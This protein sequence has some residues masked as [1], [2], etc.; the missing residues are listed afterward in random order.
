ML[1][2]LLDGIYMPHGYCLLWEPWLVTLHAASDVLTFAAYSAIPVAIWIFVSKRND[3]EMKGLARLFAA[4]ILWCG[5]THLFGFITLWRPVYELQGIVKSITAVVSVTTAIMIFPL[6][7]KA[8]A[9]PSPRQ[10]QSA[11]LKLEGEIAAHRRTL[12]ELEHARAELEKRVRER[13]RELQEATER[14]RLLFEHAPVAMIMVGQDG[15]VQQVNEAAVALFG[16]RRE[17]L[18]G[19]SVETLLPEESRASHSGLRRAYGEHPEPRRMGEGRELHARRTTGEEFPVEIGLNPL[20]GEQHPAVIASIVD[21]SSRRKEEERLRIIMRELSHRS[22]NLLAVIQGMARQAIASSASLKAFECSFRERLQ[23][24]SR[25]HDLLVGKNWTG[26]SVEELVRAQLA[27]ADR[28]DP[29][30]LIV[31]GPIVTLSPEATQTLGLALHELVTNAIKHGALSC[32]GGTVRV[33]WN[34]HREDGRENLRFTW[35]ENCSQPLAPPTRSGFGGT[36]L[37]RVV[38]GSLRGSARLEFSPS[39]ISWTLETPLSS[40]TGRRA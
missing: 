4:F 32:E 9:I 11:N 33:E 18:L 30:A 1:Q 6:I 39:G 37:E 40:L 3:L 34:F 20:P 36:V 29:K 16:D 10:L 8:L 24:L 14:F 7:P 17:D 38:P 35:R 15:N 13:T 31:D 23:G 21:I 22:K 12:G 28:R 26:V 19:T 5:L 27:I 2:R 25:S